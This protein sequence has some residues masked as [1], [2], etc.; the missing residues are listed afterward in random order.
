[1]STEPT[2]PST[3]GGRI[4]TDEGV[5]ENG[6][7]RIADGRIAEV[8]EGPAPG[9]RPVELTGGWIVPG[10]V[11]V[12]CHGGGGGSLTS[13]DPEQIDRAV[14]THRSHGT[15]TMVASLVTTSIPRLREQIRT[16][17]GPVSNGD[18]AGIHLEGPFL[19]SVR[20]GAH[21]TSMLRPPDREPL[22]E[23]LDAGGE[24]IRMVTLAPEL[25]GAVEAIRHLSA[26]GVTAA[27]GHTDALTEQVE[28]AVD[29]GATVATHLFNGMRPLHHR[30]PGPV[31]T[32]LDDER[33]TVELICDMVHLHPT[34]AR[35]VARHAGTARTVAVTDAISATDAGDGRYELGELPL[36][37]SGGEPRLED[38][39]LAGST[40]TMDAALRNLVRRC[41]LDMTEAVAACSTRPA[42]LLG[43]S[44][45]VG[46]IRSGLAADLVVLDEELRT[47]EVFKDG[48]RVSPVAEPG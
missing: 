9:D 44:G 26:S 46:S 14:A 24:A 18:V 45:R 4:V 41:G 8:G 13:Q 11:D 3:I 31:G 19:S 2:A 1:M 40:L 27:I 42:E 17:L 7:V 36:T 47:T 38:G 21:D 34:V 25:D 15:T 39:S 29:A 28:A 33:V 22:D 20:C 10:F 30:E 35:L 48:A 23:L 5:L 37:V 32:L 43:L 12:H 16:L 6:W